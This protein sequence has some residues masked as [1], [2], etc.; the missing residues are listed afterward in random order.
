M[1]N[2]HRHRG[3]T[4]SGFFQARVLVPIALLLPALAAAY[5]WY[6]QPTPPVR[7]SVDIRAVVAMDTAG[8]AR[9][10][11]PITLRFPDDHAAH[12]DFKIE[13]WYYTGNVAAADGRRFGY[14]FT[15]FR[16][17]LAP[18]DTSA[19]ASEWGTNQLY[20]GHLALTDITANRFYAFERFS[21]GAAGLAGAQARPFKVW[22][23]DWEAA[24]AGP[25]MPP[26]RLRASEGGVQLDLTLEPAKPMVLQ[27]DRGYSVKGPGAGNA[28][29][30]YSYTRLTTT[31]RVET[32]E[33][34]YDV[35][36]L[37][38]MDRE[39]SSSLLDKH[40]V[41]WDWFSLQLSDRR[42]IMYFVVREG[43]AEAQPYADGVVVQPDGSR[44]PLRPGDITV[45]A[46]DTWKSPLDGATYPSGWRMQIPSQRIDLS[47]EPAIKNQ[48]VDLSV[49]YW[50]GSVTVTG[51]SA[52][53]PVDGRGYVELTGYARSSRSFDEEL[54]EEELQS[55]PL[56]WQPGAKAPSA[57]PPPGDSRAGTKE[58]G[59]KRKTN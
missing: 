54:T 56:D 10:D 18:P 48:E 51:S 6:N 33:G 35:T 39:W 37:S 22:L 42:E 4:G 20:M 58:P 25:T 1:G 41:G 13:W 26:I 52:G 49:R 38:W 12:P 57:A 29:Y 50:E 23:E 2:R 59:A 28:S 40:Q 45:E 53:R 16:N 9:A 5:I 14:Q 36:G 46:T 17:A 34:G 47:I 43:G 3:A 8:Y 11:G 44:I 21:R 55:R 7:T 31:G 15:I 19:R 27:G 32:P 30:Y 24:Q